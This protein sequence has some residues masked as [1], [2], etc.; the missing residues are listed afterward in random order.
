MEIKR[1]SDSLVIMNELVMPNDTNI[2][3]NLMGGRLLHWMD[4]AAALSSSKHSKSL[5]V[6]AAVDKVSFNQPIKHGDVVT[7]QARVVRAFNTSMEVFIEVW[8]QN[9]AQ[10]VKVKSNEAFYT[11]V[12]LD[13][14]HKPT[15]VPQIQPL[16]EEDQNLYDYALLRKQLKLL[17]AGKTKLNDA[18]ELKSQMEKWL[19]GE[20]KMLIEL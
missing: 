19:N 6:T 5:C 7:I 20:E 2:L 8:A 4:I 11:F 17:I 18:P 3:N 16:S 13:K 1:P 12:A 10:D 14:N 9:L 15:S